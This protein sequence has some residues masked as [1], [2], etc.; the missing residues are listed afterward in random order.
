MPL[1]TIFLLHP[2]TFDIEL[3]DG[4]GLLDQLLGHE[5]VHLV[6]DGLDGRRSG[7]GSFGRGSRGGLGVFPVDEAGFVELGFLFRVAI[8]VVE[9]KVGH[10]VL[11]SRDGRVPS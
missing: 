6:K 7:G 2:L 11:G 5:S 8:K 10:E 4:V 1:K 9:K 3:I